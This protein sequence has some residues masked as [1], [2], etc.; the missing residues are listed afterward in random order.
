MSF[1]HHGR[2]VAAIAL[3]RKVTAMTSDASRVSAREARHEYE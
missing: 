2:I 3:P 1:F